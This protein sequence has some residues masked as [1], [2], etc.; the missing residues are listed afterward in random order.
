MVKMTGTMLLEH[1]PFK[2]N[3]SLIINGF[4]LD[5][6]MEAIQIGRSALAASEGDDLTINFSVLK[7]DGIGYALVPIDEYRGS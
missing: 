1:D 6:V 4:L 5:R 2:D 3:Y 7:P